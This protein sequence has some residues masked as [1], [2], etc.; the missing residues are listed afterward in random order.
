MEAYQAGRMAG[1][2]SKASG[3]ITRS[4]CCRQPP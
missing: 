1:I 2:F 3:R 4:A